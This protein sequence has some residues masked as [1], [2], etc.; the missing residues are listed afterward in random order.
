MAH[1]ARFQLPLLS[2][3]KK[4]RLLPVAQRV[5]EAQEHIQTHGE[6]ILHYTL[7][8]LP[9]HEHMSHYP[10]GDRIDH[11]TGAQYFYHCDRE[12]K[13]VEEHGHFHCFMRY[14]QIPKHIAPKKLP[15]WDKYMENPMTHIVAIGMNRFGQPMRLFTV[16]RWVT[17]EI[18]YEAK[19][20]TRLIRRYRMTKT[21]SSYWQVL[22][23]WVEGMLF[24]FSPQIQWVNHERD[25]VMATLAQKNPDT[26]CF[27]N[28]D[29]EVVSEIHIDL[30]AQIQW[31]LTQNTSNE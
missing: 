12:D 1:H 10:K 24:L 2:A 16:N 17:S 25:H 5:L 11:T 26:N 6:N 27:E 21:D 20:T 28:P 29:I 13:D 22:D 3:W 15:D 8:G 14:P 4:K 7:N 18:F 19:H 30:N 23:Q 9:V 31:L